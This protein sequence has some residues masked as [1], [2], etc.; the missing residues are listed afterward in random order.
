MTV[1]RA[2]AVCLL[3]GFAVTVLPQNAV[4]AENAATAEAGVLISQASPAPI[5]LGPR[6]DIQMTPAPPAEPSQPRP[7]A[8]VFPSNGGGGPV[9][10]EILK[11]IDGDSI[12]TLGDVQGGFG[13]A[14]WQGVDRVFVERM[15]AL[16]PER[17]RSPAMRA[18]IRRLLLTSAAAPPR[19]SAGP[20]LLALR[21]G[22]L[23]A[24]GD[25][26]SA[27]ELIAAAPVGQIE[28]SLVR[29]EVE[30]RLFR[31]DTSGACDIVRGPAQEFRGLYWQQ[32][33]AFCLALSDRRE[34]AALMADV[35]AERSEA[36]HPSFFATM[37]RLGGAAPPVVESLSEPTALNIAMMRAANLSLP[38]DV[39]EKASPSALQ[40]I[41]LSPN[42][43]VALRLVAAEAAAA[44]GVLSAPVLLQI[45]GAVVFE[46]GDLNQAAERVDANW[47]PK[48]RALVVR[49]AVAS[50][51]SEARARLLQKGFAVARAKGGAQLMFI[52]AQP[53]LA[54]IQP[55]D[56][57]AW[58]AADAARAFITVGDID[59]AAAWLALAGKKG[60]GSAVRV[61]AWPLIALMGTYPG[62]S[63]IDAAETEPVAEVT[64]QSV[65]LF[66]L[67]SAPAVA[68]TPLVTA[69]AVRDWWRMLDQ[70]GGDVVGRAGIL[71]SLLESLSVPVPSGSWALVLDRTEPGEISV[72]SAG[73]RNALRHAARTQSRGAA[74]G[75]AL[76][77]I[78]SEG[79]GARTLPAV[80][81]A[82]RT[83][84]AIGLMAEARQLALEAAVAAG[85]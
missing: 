58:F 73:I 26:A 52:A 34:E 15:I 64:T 69:D 16:L 66:P 8:P 18:M 83:L 29:T 40:A 5:R 6:R 22:A 75:L 32:A 63:A 28:E 11:D 49:A 68:M 1:F 14:M 65:T 50:P 4:K 3:A 56:E 67:E 9:Q 10:T 19:R 44:L 74:V 17:Q 47:G 46:E 24:A 62:P 70:A 48:G 7:A 36:V 42:A 43:P 71:F 76:V 59:K 53:I 45:Y 38:G 51:S 39:T 25:L 77:A 84:S 55:S 54:Q 80:E 30:A 81:Q 72:P 61:E 79:P 27:L 33:G 78:G 21:I 35:L 41:A 2:S 85:L 82:I 60:A 23:F 20:S 57:L 12:G 31:F 37:E 13:S